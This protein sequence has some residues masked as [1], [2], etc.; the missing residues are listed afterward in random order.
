[1][2]CLIECNNDRCDFWCDNICCYGGTGQINPS[3]FKNEDCNSFEQREE[4]E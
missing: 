2:S 4:G 3:P 1:M